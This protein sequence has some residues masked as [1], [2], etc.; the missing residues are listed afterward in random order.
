LNRPTRILN[1]RS[2]RAGLPPGYTSPSDHAPRQ[3]IILPAVNDNAM[4]AR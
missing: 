4:D 3:A 1:R 2:G